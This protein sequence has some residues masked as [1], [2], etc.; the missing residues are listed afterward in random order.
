MVLTL[1]NVLGIFPKESW[2]LLG[3]AVVWISVAIIMDFR[4]REVANW[5]NFSFIIFALTYRI[6][7][8]IEIWNVLW[9]VW[10]VIGL[11]VGVLLGNLFYYG[12]MF[13][14][15]DAKL[16]FGLG[17]VL[18]LALSLRENINI[19][20][21][22]ILAFVLS[23]AVYGLIYSVVIAVMNFSSLRKEF[24][25]YVKKY[26]LVVSWVSGVSITL[27]L[28]GLIF[29]SYLLSFLM[30][31]ILAS[32]FLFIYG[33]SLE[34]F[35]IK[36]TRVMDLTIGDWLVENVKVGKKIIKPNWEGL[37]EEELGIIVRGKSKNS[38]VMTKQGIPFTPAFLLGLLITIIFLYRLS[39]L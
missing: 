38:F 17:V 33:I 29:Q 31:V 9:I 34:K 11:I 16:F 14:G 20:M 22:F 36:K 19:V 7:L 27:V 37:S 2:F 30:I 6:F 23:G 8:S 5:W 39:L 1:F 18:P 15:G 32:P 25:S 3:L 35:M 10:G 13:A 12:R 21:I 4:K 26:S 28:I 24:L